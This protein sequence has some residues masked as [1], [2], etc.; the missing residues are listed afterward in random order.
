MVI[1]GRTRTRTVDP[2]IKRHRLFNFS[3]SQNSSNCHIFSH[4]FI[5]GCCTGTCGVSCHF[6]INAA[7]IAAI[8]SVDVFVT[9]IGLEAPENQ[10]AL[11]DKSIRNAKPK[12]SVYR[13]RDVSG[14]PELKGFGITIA[15]SGGKT[16]FLSYS[17]PT[18]QIRRQL[19]LGRYSVT[20]LKEARNKARAA[21][22]AIILGKDPADELADPP[23]ITLEE[24]LG[25]YLCHC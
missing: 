20:S 7:I 22:A 8:I 15:P 19:N 13:I 11:S 5:K 1:G 9:S 10:M 14:D 25:L 12:A 3:A 2:L 21:R 6:T 18:R 4:N 16:F 17:S 24:G 23:T